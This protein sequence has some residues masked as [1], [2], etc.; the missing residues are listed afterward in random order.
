MVAFEFHGDV[1]GIGFG[2]C[3]QTQLQS[4][5]T[6][7]ALHLGDFADH[8]LEVTNDAIRFLQ[9]C[10]RWSQI[11]EDESALVNFRHQ[12]GSERLV[13]EE[14][15]GDENAAKERDPLRAFERKA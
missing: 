13:T 1:A 14:R 6:G 8:L 4:G 15:A 5:T 9:R 11:V 7:S 2:H 12:V 10:A 3:R